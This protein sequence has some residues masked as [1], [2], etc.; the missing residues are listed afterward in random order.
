MSRKQW[1]WIGGLL[2]LLLM[3]TAQGSA[4][5]PAAST[6]GCYN[7]VVNGDFEGAGGWWTNVSP[8]TPAYVAAPNR[9]GRAMRLGITEV[10]N[11]YAYSSIEQQI[12]I[13]ADALSAQ[14]RFEMF[15]VAEGPA[16][17]DRQQLIVL[18]PTTRQPIEILMNQRQDA[19][20]WQPAVADM[21]IYRGQSFVLYFN[22]LNDG[23]GAVDQ[24]TAMYLDNVVLEVCVGVTATPTTTGTPTAVATATTTPVAT[25][26]AVT[27][28]PT[29]VTP[30][31]RVTFI[32]YDPPGSDL[33]GEYAL[34]QNYAGVAVNLTNWTLR[35]LAG[36]TYLFPPFTLNAGAFVRVWTKVGANTPTDLYW[37]LGAP[38]WDNTGDTAYLRD[39][40]GALVHTYSY[41]SAATPTVTPTA[42]ATPDV[43]ILFISYGVPGPD[44]DTEYVMIQNYAGVAVNLTNWTLRD[45]AGNTYLFPP[46]TLNA[47]A[48]VRVWTKVG[49]N[50]PT[51]LYWGLGAPI[52]DNTGDT[53]YLRDHYG[54]LVST[55]NYAGAPTPPLTA[56]PTPPP[57]APLTATP[58]PIVYPT[59]TPIVITPPDP[60]LCYA[61]LTNES[62][63]TDEGWQMFRTPLWPT[64]AGYPNPVRTGIRSVML[65]NDI[66]PDSRSYSSVRQETGIPPDAQTAFLTFWF[67]PRSDDT[68]GGDRQQLLLLDPVSLRRIADLWRP[69]PLRNDRS[70]QYAAFD[71][72]PYRGLSFLIYFNVYNDGDGKRTLMYLDDVSLSA[73]NSPL[74]MSMGGVAAMAAAPAVPTGAAA[75]L[76]PTG[77][78]ETLAAESVG[79]PTIAPPVMLVEEPTAVIAAAPAEVAPAGAAAPEVAS[80]TAA[81]ASGS[82][83]GRWG[84]IAAGFALGSVL[85][86]L[87]TRLWPH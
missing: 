53:A 83:I 35:D 58:T 55:F 41:V 29:S 46:F 57:T 59:A 71:L 72:T 6:P 48:F 25:A 13:P 26:T 69:T 28:S 32:N 67:W 77:A 36:N 70:W 5:S 8:A 16:D 11:R 1:G 86:L 4:A 65:G 30:D 10:P 68:D 82:F 3:A 50:T 24:T 19:P 73:C 20:Y 66:L 51:D 2:V 14:L 21:M 79:V 17:G 76:A 7:L 54:T 22:A 40:Y 27:P 42:V 52:W 74:A 34:I 60:S 80:A 75:P 38:I 44:L 39:H 37:G 62:F 18:N 23:V 15:L 64:Y 49:A 61:L 45:L 47:G 81:S 63:E 85:V 31:V 87:I 43:R 12:T 84:P 33:D 9:S 56:T 78:L